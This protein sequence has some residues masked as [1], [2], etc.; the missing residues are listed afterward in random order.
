MKEQKKIPGPGKYNVEKSLEE[1][2]KEI[3]TKN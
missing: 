1:Q 3:K 2:E